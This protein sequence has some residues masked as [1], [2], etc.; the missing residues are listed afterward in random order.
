MRIYNSKHDVEVYKIKND[1]NGN[2][3]YVISWIA[4]GLDS[5]NATDLT[6]KA[7]L[8]KYNNKEYGEGF[9]FQSYNLD[10]DLDYIYKTLG[11]EID[12]D[13]NPG[14]KTNKQTYMH[15]MEILPPAYMDG[16]LYL[17]GEP[18]DH[19]GGYPVYDGYVKTNEGY[20]YLGLLTKKQA[21]DRE[22]I[23]KIVRGNI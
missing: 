3:R 20:F 1:V 11:T 13:L 4:L 22:A 17:V 19:V 2:P 14:D 16:T 15:F 6:R 12:Y 9:V 21:K 5:Y 10:A 18:C 8:T 7:G 23:K